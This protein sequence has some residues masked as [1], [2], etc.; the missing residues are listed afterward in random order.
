[1]RQDADDFVIKP[2]LHLHIQFSLKFKMDLLKEQWFVKE[3]G[4]SFAKKLV[5]IKEFTVEDSAPCLYI[6]AFFSK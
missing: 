4:V 3:S 6:L 1:M 2:N 5:F